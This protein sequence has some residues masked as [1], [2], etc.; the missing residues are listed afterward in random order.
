MRKLVL[1]DVR[2]DN[3][4]ETCDL[5]LLSYECDAWM[6]NVVYVN[7]MEWHENVPTIL[8][9][10]DRVRHATNQMSAIYSFMRIKKYSFTYIQN[11]IYT[12][13]YTIVV[14]VYLCVVSSYQVYNE[15]IKKNYCFGIYIAHV[16]KVYITSFF[17]HFGMVY[18]GG[19]V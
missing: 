11:I 16:K 10:W 6:G 4:L 15:N 2:V 8:R 1:W 18:G 9:E 19:V 17:Y 5:W 12:L 13:G 7:E 3:I 14:V